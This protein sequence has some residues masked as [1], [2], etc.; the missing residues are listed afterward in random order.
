MADPWLWAVLLSST[1]VCYLWRALGVAM[2]GRIRPE[3]PLMR[4]IVCVTYAMLAGTFTRMILLPAGELAEVPLGRRLAACAVAL[5][6]F[7]LFRRSVFA[8]TLGG[9][10][11]LIGLN[12][13]GAA[14]AL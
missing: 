2:S 13:W 14:L 1:A 6:L 8:G 11:T 4:W 5:A 3:S 9:V 7:A 10:A 12:Y